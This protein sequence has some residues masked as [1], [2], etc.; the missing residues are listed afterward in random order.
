MKE[1]MKAG[2]ALKAVKEAFAELFDTNAAEHL[3]EAATNWLDDETLN[4]ENAAKYAK[5][6]D[7]EISTSIEADKVAEIKRMQ[8]KAS[9]ELDAIMRARQT[10]KEPEDATGQAENDAE[11]ESDEAAKKA[12]EEVAVAAVENIS[13]TPLADE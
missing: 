4:V 3:F 2:K 9:A 13:E 5:M 10:V 1:V 6:S 11:N 8:E 7:T 12:K